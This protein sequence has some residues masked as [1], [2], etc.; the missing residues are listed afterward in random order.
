MVGNGA[1]GLWT[2]LLAPSQTR[3]R[4][5]RL[6]PGTG[7]VE[8]VAMLASGYPLQLGPSSVLSWTA[9]T[10]DGSLFLLDPSADTL[11]RITA[12]ETTDG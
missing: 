1:D 12:R 4:V 3:Q 9:T 6:D 8:V 2:S 11:Y 10:F 7:K 5:V